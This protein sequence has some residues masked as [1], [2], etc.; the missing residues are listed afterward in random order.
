ML[1]HEP[2]VDEALFA[3]TLDEVRPLLSQVP[4]GPL[5]LGP[6][7]LGPLALS[8][9]A[10]GPLPFTTLE[11]TGQGAITFM[12]AP[13]PAAYMQMLRTMM[14]VEPRACSAMPL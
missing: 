12:R 2:D 10:L 3:G 4:L 5:A 1:Y 9:L 11:S 6:L 8:P 14:G 13:H 7:A